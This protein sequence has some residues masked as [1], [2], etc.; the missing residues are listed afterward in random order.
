MVAKRTGRGETVLDPVRRPHRC[1]RPQHRATRVPTVVGVKNRA[2]IIIKTRSNVLTTQTGS[3]WKRPSPTTTP[4]P[5]PPLR[6]TSVEQR[7]T[8]PDK[9]DSPGKGTQIIVFLFVL[10]YALGAR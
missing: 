6:A 4:D 1:L 2:V 10:K 3:E 7:K 5:S 8:N 9:D